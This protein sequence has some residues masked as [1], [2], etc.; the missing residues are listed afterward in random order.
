MKQYDVELELKE[1][2]VVYTLNVP[3]EETDSGL[4]TQFPPIGRTSCQSTGA[5]RVNYVR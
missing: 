3:A 2:G 5:T 1:E 4:K